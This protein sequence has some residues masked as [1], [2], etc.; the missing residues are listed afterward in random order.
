MRLLHHLLK[1]VLA[2]YSEIGVDQF[3]Q[4]MPAIAATAAEKRASL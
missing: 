2:A 3:S 4:A 1:A